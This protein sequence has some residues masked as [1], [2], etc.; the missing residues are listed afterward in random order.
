MATTTPK[1]GL[2]KPDFVDVVDVSELN[3]N[4]D[5][6]DDALTDSSTL[7]D[8]SGVDLTSPT[9]GQ[10]LQYDGTDWV[11]AAVDLDDLGDVDITT[12]ADGEA[13]IY[14][15]GDWVNTDLDTGNL[16]DYEE[17]TWTPTVSEGTVSNS[18]GQYTK[19]GNV[20]RCRFGFT[21]VSDTSANNLHV[22][23]L[24]FAPLDDTDS[25]FTQSHTNVVGVPMFV[26]ITWAPINNHAVVMTVTGGFMFRS[27]ASGASW[28]TLLYS[29]VPSSSGIRLG[30]TIT[31]RTSA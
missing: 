3:D 2:I 25:Q 27:T 26:G 8:L 18:G 31:Y 29:N 21:T 19:I 22:L 7:D 9:T 28:S 23:S 15:S 17:G 24:P 13:L 16:S 6:L 10:L 14:S 11:N 12:P 20:V 5:V 1:L 4:M 30:G